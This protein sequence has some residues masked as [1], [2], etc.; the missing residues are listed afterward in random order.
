MRMMVD[1]EGEHLTVTLMP[2]AHMAVDLVALKPRSE[3]LDAAESESGDP[4]LITHLKTN[5]AIENGVD[6]RICDGSHVVKAMFA[7]KSNKM[8]GL[9]VDD[10]F[11]WRGPPG[12]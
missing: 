2:K 3:F 5:V 1:D 7:K 6:V 12:T 4:E 8:I 10:V 9:L 11:V